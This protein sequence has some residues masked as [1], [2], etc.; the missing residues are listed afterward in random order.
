MT[1]SLGVTPGLVDY[2]GQQRWFAGKG[3]PWRIERTTTVGWLQY[4]LPAVRIERV[5]VTY[6]DR[7]HPDA[8][9][10]Q[11]PLV[12]YG[13]PVD[14]LSHAFVT[15]VTDTDGNH[16]WVYDAVHDKRVTGLWLRG[17]ADDRSGNPPSSRDIG[18]DR[19]LSF[20]HDPNA[21]DVP[22]DAASIVSGAEQSNTSLIYGDV[23]MCKIFRKV[24]P[25]LNPDIEIHA[26]L[27]SA[28]S[29]HIAAPL[30]WLEGRWTEEHSGRAVTGSLAMLQEFL[31]NASEGW[32]L[33][34][35]SVRDLFAEA[36]LHADEVG[37]DFAGE[38][39][40]LGVATAEVHRD[41]AR[42]L[43]TGV[44]GAGEVGERAAAM[45]LRLDQAVAVVPEL[46]AHASALA[47]AYDDLAALGAP[48]PVQRVHGDYHLGQVLR[49]LD[50]WRL[51]DFEGEPA[52]RLEERRELDSP[53]RDV[54]GMLRSFD[55]AAWHLLAGAPRSPQ[56]EYRA[57]E[58]AERNRSA[59][60]DGY[61][62]SAGADP[63]DSTVLLRALETDKAV[64]EAVYEA[65]N[66]PSWLRI[67]MVAIARLA[68][69]KR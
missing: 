41:L 19:A 68:D 36:D 8:E 31:A 48:V 42:T 33:A 10:Y 69:V 60:C 40:R 13:G 14:H 46:A 32:N 24:A 20:H 16:S 45:R 43:P 58:W 56:R 21:P 63:R 18:A 22:L 57:A 7:Q 61:A 1:D 62:D 52:R 15:E 26:A 3:R 12:H 11:L 47:A 6:D 67:P 5:H 38:A 50:G 27:A 53:L 17:V 25:G 4:Q 37:G 9:D 30:G 2:L 44:L 39:H 28:G 34:K 29:A 35:T 23:V 49:T 59:F 51:I 54:A 55:Y 65:R 66:R 64:Y